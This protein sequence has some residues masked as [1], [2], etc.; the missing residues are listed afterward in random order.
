MEGIALANFTFVNNTIKG[1]NQGV[2]GEEADVFIGNSVPVRAHA[3]RFSP[4]VFLLLPAI[5]HSRCFPPFTKSRCFPP[6]PAPSYSHAPIAHHCSPS[7]SLS[8]VFAH[9]DPTAQCTTSSSLNLNVNLVLASN[10]H[11]QSHVPGR[12]P[13]A[14]LFLSSDHVTVTGN[15]LVSDGPLAACACLW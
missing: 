2:A 14:A 1:V 12:A 10:K 15:V 13:A 3:S 5:Y 7:L 4:V 11:E 6:T 8:Q 9:G